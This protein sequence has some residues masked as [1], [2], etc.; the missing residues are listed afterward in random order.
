LVLTAVI[1]GAVI[2]AAA[3]IRVAAITWAT[4][5][6]VWVEDYPALI[7]PDVRV[8]DATK[9]VAQR[10]SPFIADAGLIRS[11]QS[12]CFESRATAELLQDQSQTSDV[13]ACLEQIDVALRAAPASSEL[14]LFKAS[15]LASQG[16]FAEPMMN[17]LRNA[18]RTAPAEGWIASERVVLGLKLFPALAS[19]LQAHVRSDLELVLRDTRLSR[20]LV[21]AYLADPALRATAD[22]VLRGLSADSIRRFVKMA[23]DARDKK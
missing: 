21:A 16:R 22:G 4:P 1:F 10:I 13:A 6:G 9:Y 2:S 17:A 14:W 23:R 20:P 8:D 15:K 7:D 5:I 11:L 18:Y 19:D 12:M 3:A